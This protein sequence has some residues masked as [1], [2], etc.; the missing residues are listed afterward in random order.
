MICFFSFHP[1]QCRCPL[2]WN[3]VIKCRK[4]ITTNHSPSGERNAWHFHECTRRN[5]STNQWI[6]CDWYSSRTRR[7]R[8]VYTISILLI[9]SILK[10]NI[11]IFFTIVHLSWYTICRR[12]FPSE[13]NFGKRL[14][15]NTTKSLLLN[16]NLPPKCSAQ[17]WN[18]CEYT[19]KRLEARFGHKAHSLGEL[20][21][22]FEN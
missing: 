10:S 17:R 9:S 15:T 22:T 5:Q 20:N 16:E 18:L 1:P 13:A 7:S 21:A 8:L 6:R 3:L 4:F 11:F 2:K 19:E 12:I 14:S